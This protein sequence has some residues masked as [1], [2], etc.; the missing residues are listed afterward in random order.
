M[1]KFNYGIGKINGIFEAM[2]FVNGKRNHGYTFEIVVLEKDKSI[3]VETEELLKESYADALITF[4]SIQSWRE[5]LSRIF[6]K[7]F[8]SYQPYRD[9]HGNII[10]ENSGDYLQ[11]V[12][13]SFALS[14]ESFRDYFINEITDLIEAT[15]TV[16]SGLSVSLNTKNWYECDWDD[17]VLEGMN[18]NVFIHLGVSD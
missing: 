2:S 1:D 6:K 11:D 9:T 15:L 13:H 17:V 16:Q 8:F 14:D 12:F 7:W 5:E 18:G 4:S 3:E 10:Q